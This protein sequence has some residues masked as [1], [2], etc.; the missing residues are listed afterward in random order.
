MPRPG[1]IKVL[2]LKDW[3]GMKK[4]KGVEKNSTSCPAGEGVEVINTGDF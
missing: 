4:R 1:I 2:H 3:G